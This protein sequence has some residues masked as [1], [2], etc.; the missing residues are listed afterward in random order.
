MDYVMANAM[1]NA[2]EYAMA[3]AMSVLLYHACLLYF[4]RSSV[5]VPT[6]LRDIFHTFSQIGH[7]LFHLYDYLL[8]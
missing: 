4:V 5:I 2:M 8:G 7:I 6:Q 1:V 3:N